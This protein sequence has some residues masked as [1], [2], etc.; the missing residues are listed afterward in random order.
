MKTY[1]LKK[2][3]KEMPKKCYSHT[4]PHFKI[5]LKDIVVVERLTYL[6]SLIIFF[7]IFIFPSSE[8]RDV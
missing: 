1:L 2:R 7:S 6:L 8:R 3:Y 5:Q 4:N